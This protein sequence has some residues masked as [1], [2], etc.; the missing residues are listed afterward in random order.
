[1]AEKIRAIPPCDWP[2]A[3][4]EIWT[5]ACVAAR[6][7]RPGGGAARIKSS[8]RTSLVRAYGYLLEF[9]HRNGLLDHD[10]EAGAHVSPEIIDAFIKRTP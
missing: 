4:R 10:A 2:T 6:R 5:Q 1:M 3:E 9:C 8:T 7:L